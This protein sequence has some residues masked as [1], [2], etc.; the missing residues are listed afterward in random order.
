MIVNKKKIIQPLIKIKPPILSYQ[1]KQMKKI[2]IMKLKQQ[3]IIV[4]II[5]LI[6][7][8]LMNLQIVI[9]QK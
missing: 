8:L 4:T 5:I 9:I 1:I 6:K 3:K 2:P 7:C